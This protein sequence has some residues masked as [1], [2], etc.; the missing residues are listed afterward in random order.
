MTSHATVVEMD[1]LSTKVVAGHVGGVVTLSKDA[2][3]Y[4]VASEGL[5]GTNKGGLFSQQ[6]VPFLD[7][8]QAARSFIQSCLAQQGVQGL[9]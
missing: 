2:K 3:G 7:S 9:N 6:K 1:G 5:T 4:V 8:P